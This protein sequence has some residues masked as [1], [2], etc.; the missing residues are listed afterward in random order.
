MAG[1]EQHR[2][3]QADGSLA[4]RIEPDVC[5][6]DNGR[7]KGEE[8]RATPIT[9]APSG[10]KPGSSRRRGA[11]ATAQSSGQPTAGAPA[12]R[13]SITTSVAAAAVT[14]AATSVHESSAGPPT[15]GEIETGDAEQRKPDELGAT[16]VLAAMSSRLAA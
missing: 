4:T 15:H 1:C 14:V 16:R 2:R 9:I 8:E 3:Q 6:T 5:C 13:I 11:R 7:R 10:P 12:G